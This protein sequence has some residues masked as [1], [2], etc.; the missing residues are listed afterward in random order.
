[1]NGD[2]KTDKRF[3]EIFLSSVFYR[4]KQLCYRGLG[5]RNSVCP[6]VSLSVRLSVMR[7]LW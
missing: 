5:D 7:A 2:V 4:A 6:F 3:V 1:M